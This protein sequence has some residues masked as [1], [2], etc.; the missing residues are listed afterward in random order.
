LLELYNTL[1]RKIEPFTSRKE[2][3]VKLYTCGP[4]LYREPH[5]GNYRTFLFQDI[6]QRHLEYL[7]YNVTR[8]ITLTDIEDKAI[9]EANKEKV[10]IAELTQRIS[11]ILFSE[12][13]LLRIKHPTYSP[14]SST[15]VEQSVKIIQALLEKGLAYWHSYRGAR[16]VYFD[17]LR[18]KGFGKLSNLDMSRWPKVEKRFHKDNY[19]GSPWNRGDFILWHG[20]REGDTV[21]W[22]TD[23]GK[24]RP[25]WNVQD[26]G[27]ITQYLGSEIDIACGGIDNLVRHHDY[28][29]SIIE[30]IS[31]KEFSNYW[32]HGGHLLVDGKKMSKSKGNVYYP[33]DLTSRGYEMRHLRFFLIVGDYKRSL[34]FTFEKMERA[35]QRLDKFRRMVSDLENADAEETDERAKKLIGDT[36][37]VS[38]EN[39]NRNLNVKSAFNEVFR[40][41]SKLDKLRRRNLLSKQ[42]AKA[43]VTNLRIIDETLQVIF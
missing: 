27:M 40:I 5:I 9:D 20:K 33:K 6:L 28:T 16:N 1:S 17:P 35:R 32:L 2:G 13:R 24:G 4:S 23:I 25:A 39:L 21:Y 41:I 14:R 15:T 3:E 26:A 30:G 36:L 18:F 7:G 19:P 31:E 42:D 29:I 12:L 34:N 37:R 43:A 38:K 11:D 10:N 8:L 22:E